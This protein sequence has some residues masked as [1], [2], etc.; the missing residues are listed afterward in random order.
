MLKKHRRRNKKAIRL[1]KQKQKKR[2]KREKKEKGGKS[3]LPAVEFVRVE[4]SLIWILCHTVIDG[5]MRRFCTP[6]RVSSLFKKVKN[7][8][9]RKK[10]KEKKKS[11]SRE[12]SKKERG[13]TN[14][15]I[16]ISYSEINKTYG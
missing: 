11:Q 8:T 1:Y 2:K 7:K 6:N 3:A 4:G 12:N 5:R 9:Q 13:K 10:K 16:E 15:S 14:R